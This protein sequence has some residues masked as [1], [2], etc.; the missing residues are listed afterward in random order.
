ML[1]H[2]VFPISILECMMI[3]LI[4]DF[5]TVFLKRND[6]IV[7]SLYGQCLTSDTFKFGFKELSNTMTC[8]LLLSKVL[9]KYDETGSPVYIALMDCSKHFYTVHHTLLFN[10]I[11]N[12]GVPACFIRLQLHSRDGPSQMGRLWQRCISNHKWSQAG[13]SS[14]SNPILRIYG[15]DLPSMQEKWSG[16]SCR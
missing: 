15:G 10:K 4:K 1:V 16:M 8:S 7:I 12:R 14:K 2:G 6:W 5:S 3:P 9:D 13:G 11:L